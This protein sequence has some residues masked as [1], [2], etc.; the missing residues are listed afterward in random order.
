MAAQAVGLACRRRLPD[1]ARAWSN[2]AAH[3]HELTGLALEGLAAMP[4][5][6]VVG[7]VDTADRGGAVS[8]VVDGIHPHDVGQVLDDARRRGPGRPPLRV[9]AHAALRRT[10]NDPGHVLPLQHRG[11][12]ARSGRRRPRSAGVLR[13][14]VM[15]ETLYQEIILDHYRT[16]STA[17]CGAVRR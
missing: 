12:G 3:E 5:V 11:R 10:G 7:P 14:G 17:G 6:R 8:F 9:A 1:R 15:Q 16:R 2:V 13:S 4:G